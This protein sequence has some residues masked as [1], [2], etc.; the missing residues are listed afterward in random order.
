MKKFISQKG[1]VS[2]VLAILLLSILL[3]IGLGISVLMINQIKMSG[4]LGQSVVAFYAAEAGAERCLYHVRC[5]GA[6]EDATTECIAE[7]GAGLD[8][9]C[10]SV[11]GIILNDD[12]GINY[13]DLPNTSYRAERVTDTSLTSMGRFQIT[14]RKVELDWSP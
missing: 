7:T 2:I 8:Q 13:L 12:N 3:V 9:G 4:Q 10:A 14:T 6:G 11:G 1:A 5:V